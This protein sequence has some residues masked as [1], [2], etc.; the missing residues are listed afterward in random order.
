MIPVI[1]IL[2]LGHWLSPAHS[3]SQDMAFFVLT[4]TGKVVTHGTVNSLTPS[5]LNTA[6]IKGR[7]AEFTASMGAVIGNFSHSTSSKIK[8][9]DID[10]PYNNIFLNDELDDEDIK[11]MDKEKYLLMQ[12]QSQSR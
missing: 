12:T 9:T 11:L 7:Q 1:M 8:Y 5:E 2:K 4:S 10:D 3:A 6:T